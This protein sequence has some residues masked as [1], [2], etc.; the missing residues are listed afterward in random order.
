MPL[1]L[2]PLLGFQERQLGGE[3]RFPFTAVELV[4]VGED[5]VG[6]STRRH[7]C[8]LEACYRE[9]GVIMLEDG[10]VGHGAELGTAF[11]DWERSDF[12]V[13]GHS[14]EGDGGDVVVEG[15]RTGFVA[16]PAL[17]FPGGAAAPARNGGGG[18]GCLED[19]L[20]AAGKTP[21]LDHLG[22]DVVDLV[23]FALEG[24]HLHIET[25]EGVREPTDLSPV[26][27][28]VDRSI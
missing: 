2:A 6:G 18:G 26:S 24:F 27:S 4:E 19:C 25:A 10:G 12:G 20:V 1:L 17:A 8:S 11:W 28:D 21:F 16:D 7:A 5:F 15:F 3:Q 13:G 9:V 23:L 22:D 14:V